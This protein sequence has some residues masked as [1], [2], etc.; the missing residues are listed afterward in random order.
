MASTPVAAGIR[1][2]LAM[3]DR[4]NFELSNLDV[5][6][7]FIETSTKIFSSRFPREKKRYPVWLKYQICY[8][9]YSARSEVL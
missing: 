2:A 7:N 1:M 5:E 6:K 8:T 9:I 4:E 3:A